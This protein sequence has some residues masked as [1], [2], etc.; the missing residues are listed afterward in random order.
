MSAC[1][2]D[3]TQLN[4]ISTSFCKSSTLPVRL[5]RKPERSC[6]TDE[7]AVGSP[8]DLSAFDVHAAGFRTHA[9]Q[10]GLDVDSMFFGIDEGRILG[11]PDGGNVN[12]H[13]IGKKSAECSCRGVRGRPVGLFVQG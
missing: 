12:S 11:G 13:A 5:L 1:D 4:Y 8:G 9:E 7:Q 10:I 3:G 6:C 2:P